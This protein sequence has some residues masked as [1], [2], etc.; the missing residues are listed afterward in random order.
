MSLIMSL[1]LNEEYE[2][3]T[4]IRN[5][6]ALQDQIESEHEYKIQVEKTKVKNIYDVNR[7]RFNNDTCGTKTICFKCFKILKK[8]MDDY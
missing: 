1:N 4:T 7:H 6:E 5:I 8:E 3:D 2:N